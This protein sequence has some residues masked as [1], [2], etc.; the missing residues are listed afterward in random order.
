MALQYPM[1]SA[2]GTEG[3]FTWALEEEIMI[4]GLG[5]VVPGGKEERGEKMQWVLIL[6][7]G[8]SFKGK[9]LQRN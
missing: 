8:M 7:K 3:K 1:V 5:E 4:K 9:G 2:V 6:L